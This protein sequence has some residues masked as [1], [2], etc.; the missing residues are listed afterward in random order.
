MVKPFPDFS[1]EASLWEKGFKFIAGIDEVGRGAFAG[2]VVAG[3]VAF[4]PILNF[5]FKIFNEIGINDSKQMKAKDRE[6]A[7]VWIKENALGW[8]IGEVSVAV[9]NRVGI[10]RAAKM[11]MRRAIREVNLKLDFLLI[12]AF[13]IPNV[14]GLQKSRQLPIV[15]GDQKSL[16]IAAASIIAKVYRDYLLTQLSR[17]Y[18]NYCWERNKGYGTPGHQKAIQVYGLTRFHRKQ[19]VK[20]W[21]E[22]SVTSICERDRKLL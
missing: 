17:K 11:A 13:Y 15:K 19:F 10:G 7:A 5:K 8:G 6:L 3:A 22:N 18:T 20:T 12:D 14:P 21:K 16:S 2:P 4:A 1:F 9:I